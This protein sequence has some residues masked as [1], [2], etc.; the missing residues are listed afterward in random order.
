MEQTIEFV[1][2]WWADLELSPG[3]PP[4]RVLVPRGTRRRAEVRPRTLTGKWAFVEAAD[5]H[6]EDGSTA[7]GVHYDAFTRS[8]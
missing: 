6:F 7:L 4:E 3:Q 1:T 2:D 8:G 5:L